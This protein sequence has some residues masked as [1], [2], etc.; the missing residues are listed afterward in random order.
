MTGMGAALAARA[1]VPT[2]FIIEV[3]MAF[4]FVILHRF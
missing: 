2:K 3:F 4:P 1:P